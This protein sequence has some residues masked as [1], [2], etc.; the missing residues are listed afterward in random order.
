MDSVRYAYDR[1]NVPVADADLKKLPHVTFPEGS[2][3][4]TCLYVQRQKLYGYLS[5]R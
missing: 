2:E 5:S 4:H 3:E 1:L